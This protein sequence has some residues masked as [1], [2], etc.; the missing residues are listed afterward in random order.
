MSGLYNALFGENYEQ[1]DVLLSLI[2]KQKDDFGRYRDIYVTEDHIVVHTRCG[3]GNREDYMS[4]FEEMSRHPLY[5]HDEDDGFDC[6]YADI[7]FN[8]PPEASEMLKEMAK[9]TIKPN[10]KWKILLEHL[11]NKNNLA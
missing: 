4:V 2:G 6:T 9:G 5:S 11:D 10:E 7:F 8:H 3:G 1:R